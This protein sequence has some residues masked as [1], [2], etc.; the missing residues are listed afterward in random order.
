[1]TEFKRPPVTV[2]VSGRATYRRRAVLAQAAES[3]ESPECPKGPAGDGPHGTPRF[4]M[5]SAKALPLVK[6][7]GTERSPSVE[8]EALPSSVELGALHG[9]E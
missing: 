1:M 8:L 2:R 5:V 6:L 4:P 9:T 7:H 3:P